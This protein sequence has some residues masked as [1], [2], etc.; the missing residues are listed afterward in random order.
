[1]A[2]EPTATE[3]IADLRDQLRRKD[4]E[5]EAAHAR[6]HDVQ[7]AGIAVGV[8]LARTPGWTEQDA[9]AAWD[10][11][12]ARLTRDGYTQALASYV[13]QTGSLPGAGVS[14]PA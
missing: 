6:L 2:N 14:A 1:M 9:L 4:R 12:C 11:A 10:D 5:I 3:L 13:V 7:M 8:L